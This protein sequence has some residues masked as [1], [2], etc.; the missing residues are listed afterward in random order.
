M[1][2]GIF[3]S[4]IGGMTVLKEIQRTS[5][6][7]DCI[8]IGD[9]CHVPYGTKTKTELTTYVENIIEFL[10]EKQVD[11]IVF[12]CN[13]AT[14]MLLDDMKNRYNVPMIGT[15]EAGANMALRQAHKG[16]GIIATPNTIQSGG[17][18]RQLQQLNEQ[19]PVHSVACLNLAQLIEDGLE[20]GI[21]DEQL[22]RRELI[23]LP[24]QNIDTLVLGCTHYPLVSSFI[25]EY[26]GS[27]I[28]L[29]NPAIEIAKDIQKMDDNS[30]DGEVTLYTS[31]D[32]SVFEE[33]ARLLLQESY[34]A[35][36]FY[37]KEKA[38]NV[39]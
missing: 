5:P 32:V 18:E 4:G 23:P 24:S 12:A 29:I 26:L 15:I 13:T 31:G 10:I 34:P 6:H 7:A 27:D 38:S 35:H 37:H 17:Y 36:T 14:S 16:I 33:K 30:G 2:I 1:K 39:N 20:S 21:V 25:Q 9:S 28:H 8:Y 19:M 22:L 3:D 11:I